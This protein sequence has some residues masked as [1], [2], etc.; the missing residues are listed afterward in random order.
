[1]HPVFA[2]VD[3]GAGSLA[4]QALVAG[5]LS[6]SFMLRRSVRRGMDR[7][8]RRPDSQAAPEHRGSSDPAA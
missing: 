5:L 3:P 1:M 6:A 4:L 2:Y 8:R 7:I